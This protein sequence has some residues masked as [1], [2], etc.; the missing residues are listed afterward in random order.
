MGWV[1]WTGKMNGGQRCALL[2]RAIMN[3]IKLSS[4]SV[5]AVDAA[6]TKHTDVDKNQTD[7]MIDLV[8]NLLLLRRTVVSVFPIS[9]SMLD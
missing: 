5:I 1:I 8:N 7:V 4:T 3:P 6:R 2:P 9:H